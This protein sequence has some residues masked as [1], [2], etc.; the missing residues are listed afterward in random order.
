MGKET[1]IHCAGATLYYLPV[2][3]RMPLKFGP[4]TVTAVT[5]ARVCL[6]VEGED[7]QVACG[8]GE[9][10]LS[11]TWVWP[12]SLTFEERDQAM[13][14]FCEILAAAWSVYQGRGHPIELGYDFIEEELP[15]LLEGFNRGRA[16]EKMPWAALGKNCI[17]KGMSRLCRAL[18]S[19]QAF[20]GWTLSS[21]MPCRRR[22]SPSRLRASF[23]Q[24]PAS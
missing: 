2:K 18:A 1:D 21:T 11:V 9:T 3:T 6:T 12:G 24:L 23:T 17:S 13:K 7:G 20:D 4:E 19:C 8:W 22:N 10:P 15:G 5:C 14:E 16:G